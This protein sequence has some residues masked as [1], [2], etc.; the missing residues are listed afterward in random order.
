M[1]LPQPPSS[2]TKRKRFAD[3]ETEQGAPEA[4]R[5]RDDDDAEGG[6]EISFRDDSHGTVADI[7]DKDDSEDETEAESGSSSVLPSASP[8]AS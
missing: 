3:D 6:V 4:K 7:E 1:V 5:A 8:P 2:G